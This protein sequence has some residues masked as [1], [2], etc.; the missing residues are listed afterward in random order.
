MAEV[1]PPLPQRVVARVDFGS[2]PRHPTVTYTAPAD[3][4]VRFATAL[5]QWN[6]DYRIEVEDADPDTSNRPPYFPTW[7][8]FAWDEP[9]SN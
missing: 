7:R 3:V 2:G 1:P 6:P 9:E 4:I 5:R 8:L